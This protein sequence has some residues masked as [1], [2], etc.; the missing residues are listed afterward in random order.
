MFTGLRFEHPI[1]NLIYQAQ[2]SSGFLS[3][4]VLLKHN[5]VSAFLSSLP[6]RYLKL[7]F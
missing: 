2:L 3:F 1:F 4:V 7:Q 5:L 6:Q